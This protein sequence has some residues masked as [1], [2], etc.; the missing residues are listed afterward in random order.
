[1]FSNDV[2][3]YLLG[4][5]SMDRGSLGI[6]VADLNH[7]TSLIG[8]FSRGPESDGRGLCFD[9]CPHALGYPSHSQYVAYCFLGY[10]L[11]SSLQKKH[12]KITYLNNLIICMRASSF[13]EN[14]PP[15]PSP[16]KIFLSCKQVGL[17]AIYS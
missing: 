13:R 9:P 8:P 14:P 5:G 17:Q 7:V 1:M 3:T 6:V 2:R 16:H 15:P 12:R 11:S 10:R 4:T